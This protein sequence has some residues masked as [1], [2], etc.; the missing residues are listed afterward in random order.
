MQILGS[1]SETLKI[2]LEMPNFIEVDDFIRS[3]LGWF[4]KFLGRRSPRPLW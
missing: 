1:A 2:Y 4:S 3:K